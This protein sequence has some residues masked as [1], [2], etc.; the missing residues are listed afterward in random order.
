MA[1]LGGGVVVPGVADLPCGVLQQAFAANA[2]QGPGSAP[3]GKGIANL[4]VCKAFD[5]VRG[6]IVVGISV[7]KKRPPFLRLVPR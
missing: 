2:P 4:I 7:G 5:G 6:A 3:D 1:G